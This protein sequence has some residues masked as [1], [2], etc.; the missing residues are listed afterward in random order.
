M[1][2]DT[3]EATLNKDLSLPNSPDTMSTTGLLPTAERG[4]EPHGSKQSGVE[5][6]TELDFKLS[7]EGSRE[8]LYRGVETL[9]KG[10][11][12]KG[13]EK[14]LKRLQIFQILNFTSLKN[15]Q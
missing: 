13:S 1:Q 11:F 9:K 4:V 2:C 8:N 14:V 6:H 10:L 12:S 7:S 15:F 3:G 5:P